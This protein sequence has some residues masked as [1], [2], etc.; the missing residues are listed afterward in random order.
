MATCTINPNYFCSTNGTECLLVW[1][2]SFRPDNS[3]QLHELLQRHVHSGCPFVET[4]C[5]II[6][7]NGI[8]YFWLLFFNESSDT[9]IL[10]N[11]TS[12]CSLS[13]KVNTGLVL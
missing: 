1:K 8:Y 6:T 5:G 9:G 12:G 7:K 13:C 10:R 2:L 4:E 11:A 3:I